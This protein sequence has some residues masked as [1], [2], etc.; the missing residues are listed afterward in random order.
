MDKVSRG[1][2]DYSFSGSQS[3]RVGVKDKQRRGAVDNF[4]WWPGGGGMAKERRGAVDIFL[5][6]G[7]Q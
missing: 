3:G 7:D 6:A 5:L 2:V 4:F 1:A